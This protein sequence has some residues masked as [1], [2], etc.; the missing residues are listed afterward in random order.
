MIV[1]A[2]L[3]ERTVFGGLHLF[4]HKLKHDS[5]YQYYY[6]CCMNAGNRIPTVAQSSTISTSKC[7]R[8]SDNLDD[9]ISNCHHSRHKECGMVSHLMI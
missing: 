1:L 4:T 2:I 8:T 9:T 7:E 6:N 3:R 5:G